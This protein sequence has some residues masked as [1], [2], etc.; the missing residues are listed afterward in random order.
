MIYA[1][2][3]YFEGMHVAHVAA[4]VEHR[5]LDRIDRRCARR[6]SAI[7]RSS[8]RTR[9]WTAPTSSGNMGEVRQLPR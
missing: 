2:A 5:R 1:E 8:A 4:W 9:H 7:R 6:S 3:A